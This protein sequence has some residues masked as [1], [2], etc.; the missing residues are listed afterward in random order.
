MKKSII[1]SAFILAGSLLSFAQ[2][3]KI[4]AAPVQFTKAEL[5]AFPDL[6]ALLSAINKGQDY[7][8]YIVRNFD[9]TTIVTN[10]NKTIAPISEM[11]PGGTWSVK[12]KAMI[13]QYAKTGTTFSL[14]NIVML[15][16]GKRGIVSQPVVSFIIKE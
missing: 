15:E 7:S 1:V 11:G 8:K 14:E 4:T 10:T 5:L 6:K 12:Q 13:E 2:D 9:L 3:T 16:Q